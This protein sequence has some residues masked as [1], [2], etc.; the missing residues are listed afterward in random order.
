MDSIAA[1]P[2]S[3]LGPSP[4]ATTLRAN[5]R[6]TAAGVVQAVQ[7]LDSVDLFRGLIMVIMLSDHT[8]D[9]VTRDGM[10]V[11]PLALATTTALLERIF[12]KFTRGEDVRHPGSRDLP[13]TP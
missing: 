3:T 1:P 4:G 9:Y 5:V 12:D 8:R 13:R 6:L 2:T 11:D 7:R 10:T